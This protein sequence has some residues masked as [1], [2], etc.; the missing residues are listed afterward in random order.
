[1]G[2][3]LVIKGADFS[4]NGIKA[5]SLIKK[6][7]I[8]A[9][10]GQYAILPIGAFTKLKSVSTFEIKTRII[11]TS[12]ELSGVF[13]QQKTR[14]SPNALGVYVNRNLAFV[15]ANHSGPVGKLHIGEEIELVV[16]N[17]N[18]SYGGWTTEFDDLSLVN[19]DERFALLALCTEDGTYLPCQHK[20]LS[21]IIIADG[22]TIFNATPAEYDGKGCLYDSISEEC[23]YDASGNG[24]V[25]GE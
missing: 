16:T 2:R 9:N 5:G 24:F 10:E 23:I 12:A 8:S 17:H 14:V 15:V 11:P 18:I 7:F 25:V 6:E 4:I 22:E 19:N 3:R 1:M 20:I 13:G 21:Y